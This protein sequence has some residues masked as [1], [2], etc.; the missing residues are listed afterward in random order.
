MI[1]AAVILVLIYVAILIIT[2]VTKVNYYEKREFQKQYDNV[3][4]GHSEEKL[5]RE[6]DE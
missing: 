5:K 2:N 3:L 1:I 4:F 6:N